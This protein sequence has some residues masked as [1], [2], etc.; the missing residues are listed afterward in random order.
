MVFVRREE[1]KD[2]HSVE[3]YD[4]I[5]VN[6][7]ES[8]IEQSSRVPHLCQRPHVPSEAIG[9]STSHGYISEGPPSDSRGYTHDS[10]HIEGPYAPNVPSGRYQGGKPAFREAQ[11]GRQHIGV[12]KLRI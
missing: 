11:L 1:G 12:P 2:P 8:R 9:L 6:F 4:F 7:G 5:E 3:G 10:I